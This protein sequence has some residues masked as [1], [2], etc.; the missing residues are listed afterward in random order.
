MKTIT[1]CVNRRLS[2]QASCA[3]RGS[4]TLAQALEN[5]ALSQPDLRIMRLPCMG[6]CEEGPNVKVVGGD[7]YHG[8]TLAMLQKILQEMDAM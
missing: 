4:E 1:V 3:A 2:G 7:L 6:A 5:I 8:V